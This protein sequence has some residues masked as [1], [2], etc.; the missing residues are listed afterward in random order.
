[1]SK[2][3]E[4]KYPRKQKKAKDHPIMEGEDGDSSDKKTNSMKEWYKR[5]LNR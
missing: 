4:E 3:D 2:G 1:V 5:H